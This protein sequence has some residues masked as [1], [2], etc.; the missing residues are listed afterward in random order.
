VDFPPTAPSG[1]TATKF[2][3]PM[4][5]SAYLSR[6]LTSPLPTK[7]GGTLRT[8]GEACEYM[9]AIGKERELRRHWQQVRELMLQEADVAALSSRLRLAVLKDAKLDVTALSE[10]IERW[11]DEPS[12]GPPANGKLN[13]VEEDEPPTEPTESNERPDSDTKEERRRQEEL[14]QAEAQRAADEERRRQE[15][16]NKPFWDRF[17]AARPVVSIAVDAKSHRYLR[18]KNVTKCDI[19]IKRIRTIPKTIFVAGDHSLIAIT[20]GLIGVPFTALIPPDATYDF[21]LIVRRGDLLDDNAPRSRFMIIVSWRSTR[22]TWLPRWPVFIW[23][24]MQ[25]LHA[26]DK[27]AGRPEVGGGRG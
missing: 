18:C 23:S 19:M 6:K 3:A 27:Y 12:P 17:L 8:I 2:F 7:D 1:E 9:A 14:Q 10:P 22:S 5:S 15:A 11:M 21:P 24:S 4:L 20:D 16:E 26:L 13:V 25:T